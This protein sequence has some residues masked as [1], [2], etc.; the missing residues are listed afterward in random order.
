[1]SSNIVAVS[2]EQT[3]R[4]LLIGCAAAGALLLFLKH[5]L[6]AIVFAIEVFSL[7]LTLAS[8]LPLL[9]ASLSAIITSYFFFGNDILLPFRIEDNFTIKDVPLFMILGLVAGIVSI[10]FYRG[11]R[12][13]SKFF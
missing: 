4:T 5:R 6:L 9:L 1:M 8:L 3:T 12:S 11:I 7:D 2:Y 10:Y 13:D